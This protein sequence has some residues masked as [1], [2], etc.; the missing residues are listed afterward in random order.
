M[1]SE[2]FLQNITSLKVNLKFFL[3][4]LNWPRGPGPPR[5][6]VVSRGPCD[7]NNFTRFNVSCLP[8][9]MLPPA[10][11]HTWWDFESYKAWVE[12]NCTYWG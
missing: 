12:E 4:K 6:G 2:A 7:L 11:C 1:T 10:A 5:P 3:N 9:L 8:G